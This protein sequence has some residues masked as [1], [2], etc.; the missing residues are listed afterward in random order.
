LQRDSHVGFGNFFYTLS[1]FLIKPILCGDQRDG[2]QYSS[3]DGIMLL[4]VV[5]LI[6]YIKYDVV[7]TFLVT[8]FAIRVLNVWNFFYR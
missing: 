8:F 3:R 6:N 2:V 7:L 5:T 1:S 4:H